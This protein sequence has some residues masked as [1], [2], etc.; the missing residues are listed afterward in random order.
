MA[1]RIDDSLEE[2]RWF[3]EARRRKAALEGVNT[4]SIYNAD[5]SHDI[6]T[7]DDSP[8]DQEEGTPQMPLRYW[9]G[10]Q[11]TGIDMSD[12]DRIL[13]FLKFTPDKKVSATLTHSHF[14]VDTA[15]NKTDD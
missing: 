11:T 8:K 14:L 15:T 2:D 1:M 10:N 13:N 3:D 5:D 4:S 12:V 9:V 6:N 7:Y